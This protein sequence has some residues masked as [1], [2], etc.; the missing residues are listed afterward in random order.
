MKNLLISGAIGLVFLAGGFFLGFHLVPKPAPKPATPVKTAAAAPA[1][2]PVKA[3]FTV[4]SLKKTTEGLWDLNQALQVREQAVA[5][6]EKKAAQAEA[7]LAAESKAL[8][9]T[10]RQFQELYGE[11][12]KRLQLITT[13]Q[14]EQLQKQA[15]I[16]S[17]MEPASSVDFIRAMDDGSVLRL[18][19]V[20]EEKDLSK[21]VAAW[22]EKYPADT[23]RVLFMLSRMG[24]VVPADQVALPQLPAVPA[25]ATTSG[26]PVD[27]APSD[28][29]PAPAAAPTDSTS[30]SNASPA[31]TSGS[32]PASSTDSSTPAAPASA[33]SPE[34]TPP[35]SDPGS[36][37]PPASGNS[38][39]SMGENSDEL[40]SMPGA[41][42]AA[43]HRSDDLAAAGTGRGN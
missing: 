28:S 29:G 35:P 10:H 8:D 18:F 3:A 16:Y 13:N 31:P 24:Q 20:L 40:L 38:S 43:F 27:A 34:A 11:F 9:E 1:P 17:A 42:A 21:I 5:T 6:R 37:P 36:A 25:T 30:A 4:D 26:T 33:A 2:A 39:A 22:K 32:A 12:Q 15:T 7:E 19:A 23:Q 14:Y 41:T